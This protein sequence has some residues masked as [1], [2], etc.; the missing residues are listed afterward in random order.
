MMSVSW[1][2]VA[3]LSVVVGIAM[4]VVGCGPGDTA[5]TSEK[6]EDKGG[7]AHNYKG[8][9]WCPEHGMPESICVQ[10]N[11]KLAKGFQDKGDWCKEHDV[12]ESQCFKCNPKLKEQFAKEYKDKY[13]EDPPPM[14]EEKGDKK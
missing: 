5:K 12:P 4:A 8:R 13:G 10:C 6:K 11:E 3:L 14:E 7:L 9:D 1:R 2:C